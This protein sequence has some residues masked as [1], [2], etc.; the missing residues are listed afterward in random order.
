MRVIEAGAEATRDEIFDCGA[1]FGWDY[2]HVEE[3]IERV[4]ER[5]SRAGLDVLNEAAKERAR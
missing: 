3:L 2:P 1:Q 5:M 4:W